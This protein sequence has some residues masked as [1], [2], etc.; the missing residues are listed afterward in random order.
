MFK[1]SQQITRIHGCVLERVWE[2]VP[3]RVL[4]S[5]HIGP[6]YNMTAQGIRFAE[7]ISIRNFSL[8]RS[9]PEM[10]PN[11]RNGLRLISIIY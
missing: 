10:E 6:G 2:N 1:T 11:Y 7:L 9:S 8:L 3:T 4:A 5:A